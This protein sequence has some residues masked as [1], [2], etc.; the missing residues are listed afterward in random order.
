MDT[1]QK[2]I[3]RFRLNVLSIEDVPE[4]YSSTVYKL[5][6]VNKQNVYIKIPYTKQ[7][8]KREYHVLTKVHGIID[9]PKVL[10]Y[11]EGNES[12]TGAFL[13]EAI[14]G[15]PCL[16]EI[17]EDLAYNIGVSHAK[18]HSVPVSIFDG[19]D[20]IEKLEPS[21][22]RAFVLIKLNYFKQYAKKSLSEE[23]FETSVNYIE[24]T[25]QLLPSPDG[26]A[27]IHMDFR[28]GNILVQQNRVTGIIDFESTRIGST[29]IDFT[30]INRDIW[31]KYPGTKEAYINGYNTIRPIIDLQQILPF[32]AFYDA[33]CSIGWGEVRGAEKHQSFID[34][35]LAL[36]K[37]MV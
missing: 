26:P 35:N 20:H 21:E 34:E 29:E 9:V 18:M 30:K 37:T 4:S 2:V 3:E 8:L 17:N 23:L 27:L 33:F 6:L 31:T 19:E 32:Y 36:L 28:P 5:Q 22:W 1:L 10:D 13:L 25:L 7:K 15:A 24:N 11:W 14:S 12:I 16:G